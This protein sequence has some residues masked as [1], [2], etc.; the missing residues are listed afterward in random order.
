MIYLKHISLT[1]LAL[2]LLVAVPILSNFDLSASQGDVDTNSS[3]SIELPDSPSGEFVL[4]IN[5]QLHQKT[6]NDW[7]SFFNDDEFVVIFEDIQCLVA[8]GDL[9][10][11]QMAERFQAQLPENQMRLRT[12]NPTLLVSKIE[13]GYIDIAVLSTEMA[14]ALKLTGDI[15]GITQFK[16]TGG[17]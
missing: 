6:M 9:T 5:N 8:E 2:I 10:A 14:E 3:A 13:N 1:L 4:I 15:R 11:Q 7:R 17:N 12:I 16:V